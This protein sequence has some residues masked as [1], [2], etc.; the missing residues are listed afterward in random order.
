MQIY[1]IDQTSFKAPKLAIRIHTRENQQYPM[2]YNKVSSII[3]RYHLPAVFHTD[4]IQLPNYN[5]FILNLLKRLKIV[6]DMIDLA[7]EEKKAQK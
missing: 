2:L 7:E 1:A 3:E 6:Y 5:Q 4:Y